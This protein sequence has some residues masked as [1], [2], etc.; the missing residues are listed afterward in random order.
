MDY[1]LG[2]PGFEIHHIHSPWILN[3]FGLPR[4]IH[5]VHEIH[6]THKCIFPNDTFMGPMDLDL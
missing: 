4:E 1:G 5:E 6:G 3:G 2:Y